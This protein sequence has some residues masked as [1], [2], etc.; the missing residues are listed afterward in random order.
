M[1]SAL[2]SALFAGSSA[3]AR[4]V[5]LPGAKP[6][7]PKISYVVAVVA[8]DLIGIYASCDLANDLKA[9]QREVPSAKVGYVL[10]VDVDPKMVASLAEG[11]L[12]EWAAGGGWFRTSLEE[13]EAA[14]D[15]AVRAYTGVTPFHTTSDAVI[16]T[17]RK[18]R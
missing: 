16:A 6:S 18:R 13:A 12:A 2:R 7:A 15:A 9:I 11:N 14:I 3:L 17:Q 10:A 8:G 1:A 4:A 5:G